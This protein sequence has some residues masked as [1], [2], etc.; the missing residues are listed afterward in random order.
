MTNRVIFS[1]WTL[2]YQLFRYRQ[3]VANKRGI[4]VKDLPQMVHL[5]RR[6]TL[7]ELGKCLCKKFQDK[8]LEKEESVKTISFEEQLSIIRRTTF[9]KSRARCHVHQFVYG[10]RSETILCCKN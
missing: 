7:Y 5:N 3:K 1:G 4:N 2:K 6:R 8:N 10:K 9:K